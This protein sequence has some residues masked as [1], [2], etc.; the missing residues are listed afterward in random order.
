M[1]SSEYQPGDIWFGSQAEIAT[2]TAT[3]YDFPESLLLIFPIILQGS[4]P[5]VFPN[6]Q[7][8]QA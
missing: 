1:D 4:L 3:R 8:S 7:R 5:G 6:R 2:T